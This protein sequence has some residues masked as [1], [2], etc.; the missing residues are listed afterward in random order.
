MFTPFDNR[1]YLIPFRSML[2]PHILT[3]TLVI[4]AGVAGMRAAIEAAK[5]GD[6]IVLHKKPIDSSNTAW[7][8]GGIAAVISDQDSVDAHVEDT[9]RAG[10]GLC[11][12]DV[13]RAVCEEGDSAINE[14]IGF[15][16]KFDRDDDGDMSLG[17]EGGHDRHRILHAGG[18]ATGA[19]LVRCLYEKLKATERIRVFDECF[20]L[21][22]LTNDAG[23]NG[24]SPAQPPRVFGAI[25][26]HPRYGLQIVW[27]KATILASGG[28]GQVYRETTNPRA[29]T[30]DGIAMAWRAG[31][32]VS[33]LEFMQFHPTTLYVAGSARS[34]IS[35]AVRGEGA[36][37]IDRSGRRFM[38][39][40][41]DMAELA[42]RDVVS[43][44]IVSE[45]ARTQ[46]PAVYLDL[47]E[48]PLGRFEQRF[49]GLH[50]TLTAFDLDPEQDVI[51]VHPS[52]HYTIGG[53]WT[54]D[55]G[56][57]NM[58]GLYACGEVSCTGLHGANR[59]ASNSL[60]EGLVL[61]RRAGAAVQSMRNH[62]NSP[63][64]IVSDLHESEH[65]ELDIVDVRSSLRSAMWRNVG[66]E[67]AGAKLN[68]VVDMF[69]FWARYTLESIFDRPSGWETQNLL[70]VGALM[71][72]AAARRNESR[73]VHFRTDFPKRDTE[74]CVHAVWRRGESEPELIPVKTEL[75]Q[76]ANV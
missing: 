18:A 21:D 11:D 4:G 34:L 33:D 35:E 58:P 68:D 32:A 65:G 76:P 25:T 40:Y 66:I 28:A 29:A 47:R 1:Q 36:L 42:P 60:L 72:R 51:P 13:V 5:H 54:D 10:D 71:T 31:A 74:Q 44:A 9:I 69:N 67:R 16:M 27:A 30:G 63:M 55:H 52:A 48:L 6:V 43:R 15:G 64:Q 17:R 26:H 20:S 24:S 62:S 53:V 41:H 8:Q 73:G 22:L 75:A 39:E 3:D 23:G 45:L 56:A 12:A 46:A 70:T 19:E 59:L 14:L 38:P 7:A 37:L 49:P 50:Q 61:G 57:T 2:L